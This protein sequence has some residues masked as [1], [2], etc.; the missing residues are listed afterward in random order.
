MS[1][2]SIEDL[3]LELTALLREHFNLRMQSL[4][5][6]NH[7]THLVKIARKNIAYVKTLIASKEKSEYAR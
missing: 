4:S 6:K 3:K 1:Q 7:K 5:N 2:K